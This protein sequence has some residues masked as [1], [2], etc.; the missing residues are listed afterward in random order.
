[1]APA[2]IATSAIAAEPPAAGHQIISFPARDFVS[3]SGYE[4]NVPA[5]VQ[6]SR[7]NPSTGALDLVAQSEP[8]MPQNDPKTPEFDGLV[9]VNHPGGGCWDTVTPNIR[10]GDKVRV[11]Q[12]D[13]SGAVVSDDTTTTAFV[14]TGRATLKAGTSNVIVMK[15]TARAADAQGRPLAQQL[16]IDQLEARLISSSKD[17]FVTNGRR[18][19]RAPRDG[20]IA[21]DAPGSTTNFDWTATITVNAADVARAQAA[22]AR[23]LWLG[24]DPLA[25]TELT[26]FENGDGVAG[27]PAAG[28]CTAPAEA[29]P[30]VAFEETAPIAASFDPGVLAMTFPDQKTGTPA[31]QTLTVTNL[32]SADAARAITGELSIASAGVDFARDFTLTT[33]TCTGAT[34]VLNNTCTVIVRFNPT[35]PGFHTAKLLFKDNANNSPVQVIALGGNAIDGQAPR[36]TAPTHTFAVAA[37][38][39]VPNVV[40]NTVKLTVTA[41]ASD[42]SGVASM[43]LEQ[44]TDG[45]TW[46][47]MSSTF[48]ANA[49]TNSGVVTATIDAA[50]TATWQFRATATDGMGNKSAPVASPSFRMT[51]VDDSS[52]TPRFQGS[53]STDKASS[54]SVASTVHWANAPQVGKTNTVTYTFTGSE[55]AFV[56]TVGSDRGQLS[57]SLDGGATN[58]VDLYRSGTTKSAVVYTASGLTTGSHTITLTQNSGAAKAPSTGTRVDVDAFIVK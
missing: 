7:L 24:R 19:L 21:Y 26:I 36:V 55:V 56:S 28:T 25:G 1:M 14:T 58:T 50:L 8:V 27:G 13:A 2:A 22:E 49:A 38:T 15:G 32:G 29:G 20:T 52:G 3:A 10:A 31:D 18:D 12:R 51:L 4:A 45:R 33:N 37:A 39:S 44:T 42:P 53:W 23:A 11:V 47:P 16:P 9:E 6:V 34:V 46:K 17:P 48:A 41:T 57:V 43:T 54:G 30:A 5:I 35:T 40:S